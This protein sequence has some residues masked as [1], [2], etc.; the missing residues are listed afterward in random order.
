MRKRKEEG[1][2]LRE[3]RERQLSRYSGKRGRRDDT[4]GDGVRKAYLRRSY[5]ARTRRGI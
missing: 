5:V 1:W 4:K 2:T 3:I